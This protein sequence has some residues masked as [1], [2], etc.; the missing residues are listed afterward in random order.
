[1]SERGTLHR[2]T[3]RGTHQ[4]RND[5]TS[6]TNRVERSCSGASRRGRPVR[7]FVPG[8]PSCPRA[9]RD[10]AVVPRASRRPG[11]APVRRPG[12]SPRP[13]CVPPRAAVRPAAVT[14]GSPSPIT[15]TLCPERDLHAHHRGTRHSAHPPRF[16]RSV[17]R[18][19]SGGRWGAAGGTRSR[20]RRAR[21]RLVPRAAGAA[22]VASRREGVPVAEPADEGREPVARWLDP[23]PA[24]V[25]SGTLKRRGRDRRSRRA[26]LW[27]GPGAAPCGG[28]GPGRPGRRA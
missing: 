6:I 17:N 5:Q 20:R 22:A 27:R 4:V 15:R 18:P 3:T 25:R 9:R 13:V 11:G 19:A 21:K 2:Y 8:A 26:R 7:W 16:P 12:P 10:G 1:M 14:S 28:A 24:P 23:Y